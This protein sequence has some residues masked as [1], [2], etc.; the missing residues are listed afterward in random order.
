MGWYIRREGG[1]VEGQ[2]AEEFA[3]TL[4]GAL[5]VEVGDCKWRV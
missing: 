2:S 1:W 3:G 5:G 4:G